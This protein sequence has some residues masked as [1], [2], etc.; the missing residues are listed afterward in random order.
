MDEG[1]LESDFSLDMSANI[2]SVGLVTAR[3]GIRVLSGGINAV[4]IVTA[5]SFQGNLTGNVNGNATTATNALGI[6]GS[7]NV[8]L[9]GVT[10]AGVQV[11][12]LC[13][14]NT[15]VGNVVGSVQ[16]G[17]W[18]GYDVS[19]SNNISAASSITG[20]VFYGDGSQL[21]GIVTTDDTAPSDPS[22]G[23]LWWKSDEGVLKIYYRERWRRA[24]SPCWPSRWCPPRRRSPRGCPIWSSSSRFCALQRE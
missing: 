21:S 1:V 3:S 13:T 12:G 14:A 15:F 6:S 7:P 17:N 10:A 2:D 11:S 22:D 18:N 16:G 19:A 8:T 20:S 24:R 4:G 9:G 23:A 5:S